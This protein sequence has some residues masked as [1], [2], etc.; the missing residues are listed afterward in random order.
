[1]YTFVYVKFRTS[2]GREPMS[3]IAVLTLT[4]VKPKKIFYG[5]GGIIRAKFVCG[6]CKYLMS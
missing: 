1:M 4:G 2:N 6:L 5:E 3:F